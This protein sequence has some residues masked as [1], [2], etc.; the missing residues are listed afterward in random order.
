MIFMQK[1]L[2]VLT[3]TANI[4]HAFDMN[5]NH[6]VFII[7]QAKLI[8]SLS[9]PLASNFEKAS[10]FIHFSREYSRAN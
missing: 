8:N 4:W 2:L 3:Y 6:L 10:F 9:G 5:K 7:G 1:L